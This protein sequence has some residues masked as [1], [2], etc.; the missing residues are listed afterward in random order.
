MN[1]D[2]NIL[3]LVRTRCKNLEATETI[4]EERLMHMSW[5]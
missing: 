4:V 3:P 5:R 1:T 2:L